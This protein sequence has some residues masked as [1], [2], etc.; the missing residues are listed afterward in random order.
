[1]PG[2]WPH[3]A[4]ILDGN[5]DLAIVLRSPMDPPGAGCAGL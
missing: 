3:F 4:D 5:A 1:M 2:F